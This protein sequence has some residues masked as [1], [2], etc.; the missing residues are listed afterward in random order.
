ML[1]FDNNTYLYFLAVLPVMLLVFVLYLRWKKGALKRFGEWKV[2]EALIPDY[3]VNRQ[4]LKFIL[5][6]LAIVFLVISIANPQIGSRLEKIERKGIDLMIALDVS[7]SMLAS[8]IS[9]SRLERARQ[10][11]SRLIR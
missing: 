10:S 4:I 3:S 7:N 6:S 9:P 1:R 11:I 2:I 8:D 5:F